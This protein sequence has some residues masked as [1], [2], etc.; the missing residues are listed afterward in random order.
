[1]SG[2]T[3][4]IGVF[5]FYR[6]RLS[7]KDGR[8]D[9]LDAHLQNAMR[10]MANDPGIRLAQM[11][12][13]LPTRGDLTYILL[14]FALLGQMHLFLVFISYA[15]QVVWILAIYVGW[16]AEQRG[17]FDIAELAPVE[18]AAAPAELKS[19]HS[20]MMPTN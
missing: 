7:K 8:P 1:V 13:K 2:L 11:L 14:G 5:I 17:L 20:E 15:V 9:Q 10:R 16:R 19:P 18:P 4:S 12:A 6:I 3:L